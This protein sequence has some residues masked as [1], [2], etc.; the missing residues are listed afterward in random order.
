[1]KVSL[2]CAAVRAIC[3]PAAAAWPVVHSRWRPGTVR[4]RRDLDL[5]LYRHAS[6]PFPGA[7]PIRN[8]Q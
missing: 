1:M 4:Q 7:G 3:S 5:P 8:T 2:T 6:G